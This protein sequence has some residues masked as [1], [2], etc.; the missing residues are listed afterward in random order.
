MAIVNG[1]EGS[2][3][4]IDPTSNSARTS[5]YRSRFASAGTLPYPLA[6]EALIPK[7]I[8]PPAV[9]SHMAAIRYSSP[10]SVSNA[11]RLWV[12][13]CGHG[14]KVLVNRLS[15]AMSYNGSAGSGNQ[16][17]LDLCRFTCVAPILN[18][19][20]STNFE[21]SRKDTLQLTSG[22]SE[23]RLQLSSATTDAVDSN[24]KIV[25]STPIASVI[26]PV[27]AARGKFDTNMALG[28]P[29]WGGEP[30]SILRA[31]EGLLILANQAQG[32]AGGGWIAGVTFSGFIEW[33]ERLST[34]GDD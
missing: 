13:R 2:E 31:N 27:S 9:G 25:V 20:L 17:T 12:I 22:I 1:S 7:A 16:F 28:G 32:A 3:L 24:S 4:T 19:S 33:E 21:P 29:S 23:N 6:T 30:F 5:M 14:R 15:L 8:F 34:N 26:F 11:V 18:A 10:G